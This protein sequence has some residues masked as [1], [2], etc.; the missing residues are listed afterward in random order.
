MTVLGIVACSAAARDAAGGSTAAGPPERPEATRP[1]P[2]ANAALPSSRKPGWNRRCAVTAVGKPC[3]PCWVLART[4]RAATPSVKRFFVQQR[5]LRHQLLDPPA[6]CPLPAPWAMYRPF[7]R[8]WCG[9]GG[10]LRGGGGVAISAPVA[11]GWWPGRVGFLSPSSWPVGPGRRR[12]LSHRWWLFV[13]E[14]MCRR[15]RGPS[16]GIFSGGWPRW[17]WVLPGALGRPFFGPVGAG[18]KLRV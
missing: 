1:K 11:A 2:N 15:R 14:G 10:G 4:M 5:S 17:P 12:A 16:V 18:M 3:S 8:T 6:I 13:R 9:R 7:C